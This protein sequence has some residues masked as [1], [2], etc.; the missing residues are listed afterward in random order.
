MDKLPEPTVFHA[1]NY[2]IYFKPIK[3]YVPGSF[4]IAQGYEKYN[5]YNENNKCIYN[6]D[7]YMRICKNDTKIYYNGIFRNDDPIGMYAIS[8]EPESTINDLKIDS[9]SDNEFE[10]AVKQ[11]EK[12]GV[13]IIIK[14]YGCYKDKNNKTS[15]K[16]EETLFFETYKTQALGGIKEIYKQ[17]QKDR[18]NKELCSAI[19]ES[20]KVI[21]DFILGQQEWNNNVEK[22]IKQL[23]E[24]NN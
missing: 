13:P 24:D 4:I 21:T 15:E 16:H 23:S 3:K 18:R 11:Q 22:A 17:N 14:L 20:S 7:K 2:A 19:T 10:E 9:Y 5:L 8:G 1:Y 12:Y 6:I